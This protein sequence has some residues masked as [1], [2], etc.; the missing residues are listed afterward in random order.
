MKACRASTIGRSVLG[1]VLLIVLLP[2]IRHALE[3]SMSLHMLVD[4]PALLLAGALLASAAP[5]R[6]RVRL[7]PWNALGISG[8]AACALIVA[9]SMIPRVLDL[10]LVDMRVEAAKTVAL[11]F[12]GAVLHPSWRLAGLVVQ[13]FFLG[14]VLPMTVIVGS[15]YQDSPLRLCNAYRLD[16]QHYLGQCLVW[17]AIVVAVLWLAHAA[18]MLTSKGTGSSTP[19][20]LPTTPGRGEPHRSAH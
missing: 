9:V 11:L 15:L 7:A 8:L 12:A 19:K 17:L 2:P 14:N 6:M 5:R 16:D 20:D 18:R 3:S 4:Y 1:L 10:A 13:G